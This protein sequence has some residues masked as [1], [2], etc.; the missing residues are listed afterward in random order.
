MRPISALSSDAGL[1]L[2]AALRTAA[3]PHSCGRGVLV[4]LDD[5][6]NAARDVTKTSVARF[7]TFRTPDFEALGQIDGASVHRDRR[8]ERRHAPGTPFDIRDCTTLP[9]AAVS[10]AIPT[11]TARR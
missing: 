8:A 1:N 11:R 7:H 10:Y 3:A 6:I 2:V 5:G 4:V 9:R